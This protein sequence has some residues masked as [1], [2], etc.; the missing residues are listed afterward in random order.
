[1]PPQI[2]EEPCPETQNLHNTLVKTA[3]VANR[4][5]RFQTEHHRQ[6]RM[7]NHQTKNGQKNLV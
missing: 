7:R 3:T 6:K 4:E 2:R 1:M 5:S